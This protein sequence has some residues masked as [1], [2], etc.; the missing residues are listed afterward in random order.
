MTAA[1]DESRHAIEPEHLVERVVHRAQIRID[2]LRHIAG[3]EAQAFSG[4]DRRPNQHDPPHA[5]GLQRFDRACD[6]KIGL[7]RARRADAERQIEAANVGQI[8]LLVGATGVDAAAMRA[9][10]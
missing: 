5:I 2:F 8:L 9:H 3:Q 1:L 4:F 6:R 7:A 10:Q